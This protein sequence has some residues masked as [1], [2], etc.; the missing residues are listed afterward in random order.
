MLISLLF[1]APLIFLPVALALIISLTFH[2]VS[3]GL[4][5]LWLGDT[6]ARDQGRLSFNPLTH[7][8][9]LGT[10]MLLTIGFG[11]GKPVPIN[12]YNLRK[13]P[14]WG[15]ALVS[16]AGPVSNFIMLLVFGLIF[17]LV[18]PGM[19]PFDLAT[20]VS[21]SANL[22]VILLS[23]LVVYNSVLMIFNL[24]P[25]PPLDG[26]K[27]LQTIL[28]PKYDQFKVFMETRGPLILFGLLIMDSL[29]GI[30][31]FSAL[32]DVILGF[33]SKFF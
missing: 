31:I 9:P 25:I 12:Y 8:D 14:K 19:N 24:I 1:Q 33:F 23:F 11:W 2:E 22:L 15:P 26:A 17:K 30:G 27:L 5:A 21:G 29:L 4:V 7:L 16:L 3:H 20:I 13:A 10:V 6:T 28:P 32:F 18:A